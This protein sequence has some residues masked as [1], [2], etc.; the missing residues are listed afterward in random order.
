MPGKS[1]PRKRKHRGTQTGAID[2]RGRTRPRNRQEAM[3]QARSKGGGVDRR[4]QMPTWNGAIK[5][6]LFFAA[7]LLPLSTLLFKQPISSAIV[8]TVIA[9]LFYI[10]LG[11]YTDR[12]FYQR[13][14]ARAQ[15]Q[16]QQEKEEA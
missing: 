3:S 1:K 13:R 9:A 12:F 4:S 14:V 8:L 7:L 5:R 15:R 16:K 2:R 10:P 11:F 6:G